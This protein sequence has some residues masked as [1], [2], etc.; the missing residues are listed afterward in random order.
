MEYLHVNFY[1]QHK[2]SPSILENSYIRNIFSHFSIIKKCFIK[3]IHR[4]R[5][6][7]ILEHGDNNNETRLSH[8]P[9]I[10]FSLTRNSSFLR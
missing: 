6:G 2:M 5:G 10:S 4:R 1:E 9:T 3:N 8:P 7:N